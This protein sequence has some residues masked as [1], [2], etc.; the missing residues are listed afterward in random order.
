MLNNNM[1]SQGRWLFR[2]RSYLPLMFS[3]LFIP[4]FW[5]F[6]HPFDSHNMD[7]TWEGFCLFVGMLGLVIRCLVIGYVPK[8]TSGRNTH[9]QIAD[10]LNTTGLYSLVRNPLYLGNFFMWSAPILF[11]H[12]W[13]LYAVYVL[14]FILYYERIIVTEENFLVQKFGET[15]INWATKT[16]VIFPKKLKWQ[17]PTMPFSWRTVIRREY[18]GFYGL[19]AVM[20]AMEHIG[21]VV[22]HHAVV[23]DPV[24]VGLFCISTTIYLSVRI[25]AKFTSILHVEGRI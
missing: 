3:I 16:P 20:T 9:E 8:N 6:H 23:L 1:Q 14:A 13:W 4:A 12:H 10:T 11:L 21:E 17:Q 22:V 25:L 2:W 19:V 15:Y 7:L 5:D 24:W 18:H